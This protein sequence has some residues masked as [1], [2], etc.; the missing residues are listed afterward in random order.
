MKWNL[1]LALDAYVISS[2][3]LLFIVRYVYFFLVRKEYNI[4]QM[5]IKVYTGARERHLTF[6][7]SKLKLIQGRLYFT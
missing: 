6:S 5:H 4:S 2:M 7:F 3:L 1:N